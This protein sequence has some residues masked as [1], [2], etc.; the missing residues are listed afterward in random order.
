MTNPVEVIG[1]TRFNSV[2]GGFYQRYADV[3]ATTDESV[4]FTAVTAGDAFRTLIDE[5]LHTT[6]WYTSQDRE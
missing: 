4:D 6:T 5:W 1:V 3:G 2:V